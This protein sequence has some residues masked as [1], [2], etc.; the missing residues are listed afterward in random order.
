MIKITKYLNRNSKKNNSSFFISFIEVN[1]GHS[2]LLQ[3]K[4]IY[5]HANPKLYYMSNPAKLKIADVKEICVIDDDS[6]ALYLAEK[7]FEYELPDIPFKGFDNVNTSLTYLSDNPHTKRLILVDLNMPIRDGWNFLENYNFN[8]DKD[9]IFILSSSEN[10]ADKNKA[11][12][13]TQVTGYIEK[14]ITIERVIEI[15]NQY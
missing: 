7:I 2:F 8:A 14:P 3:I 13:F 15:R 4:K 6:I 12:S 11:K 10:I 1:T 5:L 9:L